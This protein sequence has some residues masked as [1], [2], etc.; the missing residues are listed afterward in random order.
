MI[1]VINSFLLVFISEMGDKTQLLALVLAAKFKKPVPIMAG[2][3]VATILNH[4][5]ASYVGS[6]IT[7]YVSTDILK[8]IL[9]FTFIIFGLWMLI[10]D[11]DEGFK[12]TKGWGPFLTT[13]VA[14]FFAEMG[15]KTQ[16]ATVALGAKYT[17][18]WMVTMG[19][20]IGMLA[21]DG[22]AVFF[23]HRFTD[24]IPM[25]I[26]HRVASGLFIVFGIGILLGF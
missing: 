23:G 8:W 22:L 4:A 5:L 20:T 21:A 6:F 1:A 18:P 14:F 25:N 3:L 2:I 15:D 12:E 19:T 9:G 11:K 17:N 7:D 24:R 13:T 26:V 16:L 10:P